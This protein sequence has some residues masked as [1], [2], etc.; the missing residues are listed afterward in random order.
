MKFHQKKITVLSQ[1]R[2]NGRCTCVSVGG[3][4]NGI[5]F[6]ASRRTARKPSFFLQRSIEEQ[7]WREELTLNIG[8]KGE[9]IR[10]KSCRFLD[11]LLF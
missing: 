6:P 5:G 7:G 10:K 8:K 3:W 11:H 4:G 2:R 1:S 9:M